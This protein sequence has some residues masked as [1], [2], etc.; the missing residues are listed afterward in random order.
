M[1]WCKPFLHCARLFAG[2]QQNLPAGVPASPTLL[3]PRRT[4]VMTSAGV[5]VA[6]SSTSS[7]WD[8]YSSTRL[9]SDVEDSCSEGAGKETWPDDDTHSPHSPCPSSSQLLVFPLPRDHAVTPETDN[10]LWIY[11]YIYIVSLKFPFSS[12]AI[13]CS[14][15]WVKNAA[16]VIHGAVWK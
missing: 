10:T 1:S 11:I 2:G 5:K 12:P 9:S 3:L 4:T 7:L 8:K 6:I 15:S 14:N 16:F 13:D